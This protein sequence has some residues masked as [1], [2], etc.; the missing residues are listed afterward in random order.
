M[1]KAFNSNL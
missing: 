1:Y